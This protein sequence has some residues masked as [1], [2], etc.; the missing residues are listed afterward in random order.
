MPLAVVE[1][2][3]VFIISAVTS[4]NLGLQTGYIDS[5]NPYRKMIFSNSN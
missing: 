1:E 3:F 5:V 4:S 2:S